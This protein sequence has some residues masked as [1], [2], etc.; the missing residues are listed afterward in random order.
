MFFAKRN[1]RKHQ[2]RGNRHHS[3]GQKK[4]KTVGTIRHHIFFGHH[5]DAVGNGLKQTE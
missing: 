4:N 2:H 3:R 5:F 1:Y